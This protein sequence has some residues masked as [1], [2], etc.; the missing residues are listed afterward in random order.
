MS[1]ENTAH[2]AL[3]LPAGTRLSDTYEIEGDIGLG[4]MAE[5]YRARNVHT[6]E[7]VAIKLVLPEFARD[8]TILA[9]FKKEATVLSRLRHDAIVHYHLFT[10]EREMDRP[11]LV[12][13][14]VD[15]MPLSDKLAQGPIE[16]QAVRQMLLR[17]AGGLELAH[18]FGVVHRDL[19]PDNIILPN[20]E[21]R[22]ARIIDFGIAKAATIGEGT[23]LGGNFAGKYNYVSPEQ[24]GLYGGE[25]T[26]QSDI[27][28]LGLVGAA[29]VLGHPLEMSGSHAQVLEKRRSVPELGAIDPGVKAVL[30][31]M[32][33]PEPT[34]RPNGMGALIDLLQRPPAA[35]TKTVIRRKDDTHAWAGPAIGA[36]TAR[37]VT[38]R[39]A[40][41]PPSAKPPLFDPTRPTAGAGESPFGSYTPSGDAPKTAPPPPPPQAERQQSPAL[42][43]ALILVLLA[44]GAAGWAYTQ[45][46]FGPPPAEPTPPE[47]PAQPD[48]PDQTEEPAQPEEPTQ[49]EQVTQP[50]QPEEPTQPEGPKEPTFDPPTLSPLELMTQRMAWVGNYPMQA[51]QHMATV[52][53]AGD[54]VA[55]EGYATNAAVFE[56]LD[57][58][59]AA[60]NGKAPNI[61]LQPITPAQCAVA[62]FL[63]A[64]DP[65]TIPGPSLD[66]SSRM[67]RDGVA[68]PV[69]LTNSQGRDTRLFLV[70]EEGGIYDISRTLPA[71]GAGEFT[72]ELNLSGTQQVVPG[73]LLAVAF[74]AGR[75]V[76]PLE[77]S[78]ALTYLPQLAL[79]VAKI[80]NQVSVNAQ[81]LQLSP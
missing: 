35:E 27:Y 79:D 25:V 3:S 38:A 78:D 15:G 60:L 36:A 28:S 74:P 63:R 12:M 49:P 4:G 57:A 59:F 8:E 7:P 77:G 23:V 22:L 6:G 31:A 2:P 20:G 51:C 52:S 10:V 72:L 16:P 62:D 67:A 18:S 37:T 26:Q 9:L 11:Y 48:E 46:W 13:D 70:D 61:V 53:P 33:Q 24:L 80:P 34:A 19:S 68:L 75:A 1:D 58:E 40:V 30:E 56:P 69:T 41:P 45:G 42:V 47:A 55:V 54:T 5:V 32:L 50:T 64:I 66:L 17:V 21:V 81:Y 73:I 71:S 43:T 39:T 29:A 76:T 44:G 14:F 65:I